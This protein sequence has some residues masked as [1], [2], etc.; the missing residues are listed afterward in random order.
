MALTCCYH[1]TTKKGLK[2][3]PLYSNPNARKAFKI[4]Q[5]FSTY[6]GDDVRQSRVYP[7]LEGTGRCFEQT[8]THVFLGKFD[9]CYGREVNFAT[10]CPVL[11]AFLLEANRKPHATKKLP[12][13]QKLR[14]CK[15]SA[16]MQPDEQT[17]LEKNE[18][19]WYFFE[20]R[21]LWVKVSRV[22]DIQKPFHTKCAASVTTRAINNMEV[23]FFWGF[24]F[25]FSE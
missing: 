4:P 19:R 22:F 23:Y 6:E 17:V 21:R 14:K 18:I 16:T 2:R 20:F 11:G 24:F 9:T 15:K 10:S 7:F 3:N 13:E 8:Y 25:F 5:N 1:N 12:F